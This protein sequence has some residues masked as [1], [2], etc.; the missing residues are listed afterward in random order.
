MEYS[1]TIPHS[2]VI[3]MNNVMLPK[4]VH[5]SIN[6]LKKYIDPNNNSCLQDSLTLSYPPN[7]NV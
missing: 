4:H 1:L 7:I 5:P 3:D 2:I 6:I